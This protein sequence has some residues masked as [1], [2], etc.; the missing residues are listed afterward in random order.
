MY[1]LFLAVA[2]VFECGA[3]F[4]MKLSDGFSQLGPSIGCLALYGLCFGFFSKALQGIPLSVAYASWGALASSWPR[5]Y[6]CSHS[7]SRSMPR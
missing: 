2:V 6:R 7:R 1:Y 3:T 4:Y 5:G